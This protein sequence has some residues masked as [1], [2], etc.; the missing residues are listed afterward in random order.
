M[1]LTKNYVLY[2]LEGD[3]FGTR[4]VASLCNLFGRH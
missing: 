1:K 3:G 4:R 2:Y